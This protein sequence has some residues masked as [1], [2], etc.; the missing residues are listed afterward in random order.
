MLIQI[1]LK[2]QLFYFMASAPIKIIL[3]NSA[4]FYLEMVLTAIHKTLEHMEKAKVISVLFVLTKKRC[5]IFN[6][7]FIRY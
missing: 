5:T 4:P 6:H 1:N 2:P 7:L 3:M